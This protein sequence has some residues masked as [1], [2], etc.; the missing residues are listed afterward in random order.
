[1][2]GLFPGLFICFVLLGV[3]CSVVRKCFRFPHPSLIAIYHSSSH[4]NPLWESRS[5]TF[6]FC[7]YRLLY[8][9][10]PYPFPHGVERCDTSV[11]YLI[12]YSFDPFPFA[13]RRDRLTPRSE[14][15]VIHRMN[16]IEDTNHHVDFIASIPYPV[17]C[18]TES[19]RRRAL[20]S[21]AN[22]PIKPEG[23]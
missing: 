22:P 6:I 8:S 19:Q 15:F 18:I 11:D 3:I 7:F 10:V 16:R 23:T 12:V 14:T 20:R 5:S 9:E 21:Y 2:R 13:T 1:M 4:H 17:L